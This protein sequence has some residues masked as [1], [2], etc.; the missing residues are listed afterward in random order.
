[1]D[2]GSF[3]VYIDADNIYKDIAEDFESRFGT[4]IYELDRLLPKGKNEKIIGLMENELGGKTMTKFVELRPK[5]YSYLIDDSSKDKKAKGTKNCVIKRKLK[6]KNYKNYLEATQLETKM[7]Y[8]EK[9]L[10][11]I[12]SIKKIINNS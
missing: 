10:T 5:S 1:M 12:D 6:F 8:L 7:Y 9:N 4:S 2:T 3:I 11:D